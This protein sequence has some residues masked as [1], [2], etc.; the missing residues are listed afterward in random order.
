MSTLPLANRSPDR[1]RVGETSAKKPGGFTSR[2]QR[3]LCSCLNAR[4]LVDAN[5]ERLWPHTR[6]TG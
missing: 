6:Q 1:Q 2:P 4:V 3:S 5:G